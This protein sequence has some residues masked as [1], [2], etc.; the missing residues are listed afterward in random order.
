[1]IPLDQSS[2]SNTTDLEQSRN[3]PSIRS[4]H[5]QGN[6][7]LSSLDDRIDV[8][9]PFVETVDEEATIAQSCKCCSPRS[10]SS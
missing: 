5:E 4:M 6:E 10:S 2:G 8:E 9:L 3:R 1:M 7:I